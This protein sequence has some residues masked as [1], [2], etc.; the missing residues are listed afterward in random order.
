V[1]DA[2][3]TLGKVDVLGATTLSIATTSL[4]PKPLNIAGF[5]LVVDSLVDNLDTYI[6][7]SDSIIAKPLDIL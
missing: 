2:I 6:E 1:I 5:Y 7:D 4:S 3:T